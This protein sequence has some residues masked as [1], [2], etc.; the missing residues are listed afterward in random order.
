[1]AQAYP[2]IVE[3]HEAIRAHSADP[4]REN[5]ERLKLAE[6]EYERKTFERAKASQEAI[7]ERVSDLKVEQKEVSSLK[8]PETKLDRT[9]KLITKV[10][11][12]LNDC[13][14]HNQELHRLLVVNVQN[15][16]D[17]S[18]MLFKLRERKKVLTGSDATEQ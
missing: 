11:S 17:L 12:A 1:M 2:D 10:S 13:R 8:V 9:K 4:S 3:Y 18:D 14:V 5:T 7:N 16:R 6:A 15:K